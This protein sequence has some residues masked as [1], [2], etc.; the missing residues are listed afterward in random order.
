MTSSKSKCLSNV[1]VFVQH[2]AVTFSVKHGKSLI[3]LYMILSH[4]AVE[5]KSF[6]NW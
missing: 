1:A 6:I 4:F 5:M 3:F 2:S